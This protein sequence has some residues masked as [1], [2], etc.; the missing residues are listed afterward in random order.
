MSATNG[1][2][3]GTGAA[4]SVLRRC[5]AN[6]IDACALLV[7][8]AR[9]HPHNAWPVAPRKLA[10]AAGIGV[11]IF[12]LMM[13]LIDAAVIRGVGHLPGW[14]ERAFDQITD[15]GKSGW[16][17]WPLGILFLAL[18]SLPALPRVP[19][20]ALDAVMVRV[21]YLFLA[22]AV[23]G[24]FVNIVK[25]I[26]GRVRPMVGGSLDPYLFSPFT[27]PA[28][29]ASLPS[30]HAATAF[31]VLVAFGVLWPRARTLLWVYALLIAV[32]RV[33]VTAHYP[34]DVLA[35]AVLGVVGAL[36]VRRW[37]ALRG[38]GFSTGQDGNLYQKPGPSLRRIKSVARALLSQ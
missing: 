32:S 37:F 7:R 6:V 12:L 26:F 36:L 18:A 23:P 19:Q 10:I 27:W 3:N 16:F 2:N 31:S 30:G 9:L 38:L 15:F 14:I 34:S 28:D 13:V 8:R 33:V 1:L 5:T 11:L 25:H 17:L 35:G 21:G 29:Y 4:R 20:L 22:I 24:I